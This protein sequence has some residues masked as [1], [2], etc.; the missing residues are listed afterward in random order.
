M[1]I[2]K[3]LSQTATKPPRPTKMHMAISAR[4]AITLLPKFVKR[5][6]LLKIKQPGGSSSLCS[7]DRSNPSGCSLWLSMRGRYSAIFAW[8]LA[9]SGPMPYICGCSGLLDCKAVGPSCVLSYQRQGQSKIHSANNQTQNARFS[10]F[11][12]LFRQNINNKQY[13]K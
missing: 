6:I 4:V 1:P 9:G 11:V 2:L 7:G 5:F 12:C 10:R 3:A 8:M 13:G